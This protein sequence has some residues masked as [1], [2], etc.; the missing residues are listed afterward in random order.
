MIAGYVLGSSYV[1]PGDLVELETLNPCLISVSCLEQNLESLIGALA[2]ALPWLRQTYAECNAVSDLLWHS[3]R[4][5]QMLEMVC[6]EPAMSII[7]RRTT[8]GYDTHLLLRQLMRCKLQ[9]LTM[10]LDARYA[11]SNE[12]HLVDVYV[13]R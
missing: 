9:F 11:A 6:G 5:R 12:G 13:T 1:E 2:A 3:W 8:S 10:T 7:G 4:A